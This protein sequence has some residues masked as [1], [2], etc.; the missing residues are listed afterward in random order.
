MNVVPI[1][2]VGELYIGGAGVTRGYL[3]RLALTGATFIPNPFSVEPGARLYKTGDLA[4]FLFE[5]NIEFLGRLDD[6]LKIRG[7]RIEI[8]EVEAV[9]RSHKSI[10]EAIILAR[11]DIPGG[12]QLVAYVVL[13]QIPIAPLVSELRNYLAQRLPNYMV[14]SIFVRLNELPLTPNGKVDRRALPIPNEVTSRWQGSPVP[15][16][17][18]IEE[19]VA[20]IW[21]DVLGIS[22]VGRTD[23]FFE[24]GGHSLLATQVVSRIRQVFQIELPLKTF[25]EFPTVSEIATVIAYRQGVSG[26]ENDLPPYVRQTASSDE[27]KGN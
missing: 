8:G 2:A 19:V 26:R 1:G 24:L 25:F 12:P 10:Q 7:F 20:D 21:A 16:R 17:T 15:P 6:Q 9:L 18:P 13:N 4:R 11:N 22:L 3:D 23:N 5:G 14:P 27:L